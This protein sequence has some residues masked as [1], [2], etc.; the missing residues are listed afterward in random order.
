MPDPIITFTS[1]I[2]DHLLHNVSPESRWLMENVYLQG[3][4]TDYLVTT[5]QVQSDK[6]DKLDKRLEYTNGKVGEAIRDIQFFK[7][8]IIFEKDRDEHLKQIVATK[9]FLEKLLLSKLF[10]ICFGLFIVGTITIFTNIVIKDLFPFLK[11]W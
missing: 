9:M 10:W 7:D 1:K 3:Q 6:L 2:P 4:K 5:Q 8:K 11:K